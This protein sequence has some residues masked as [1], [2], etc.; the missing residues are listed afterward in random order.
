ML[1]DRFEASGFNATDSFQDRQSLISGNEIQEPAD[2]EQF[3]VGNPS[4]DGTQSLMPQELSSTVGGARDV[5]KEL[6]ICYKD[7]HR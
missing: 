4:E 3:S 2:I 5:K 1:P 6:E 7:L